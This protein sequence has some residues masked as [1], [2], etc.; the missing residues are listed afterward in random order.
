MKGHLAILIS[1]FLLVISAFSAAAIAEL[2]N[3]YSIDTDLAKQGS[4]NVKLVMTFEEPIQ[5]FNLLLP[6]KISN[7]TASSS[8]GEVTCNNQLTGVSLISCRMNLTASRKTLEIGFQSQELIKNR[9]Q[10]YVFTSDFTVKIPSKDV[11]VAIRLPEGMVLSQNVP[12]GATV[13]YTNSTSTDGRRITVIWRFQDISQKPLSF[14][15]FY[16]PVIEQIPSFGVPP[17]RVLVLLAI[18]IGGGIGLVIFRRHRETKEVVF[19]VLD[20]FEKR[21]ISAIEKE[22]GTANQKKVVVE[23]NLSKA[24]VSRVVQKLAERGLLEV[25]RRGRTNIIRF[26]KKKFGS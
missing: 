3:S 9:D 23:T 16:E 14:Q 4:A 22:G 24:K 2:L 26:V 11:F 13:P 21:V 10:G 25:E 17:L 18:I 15:V 1:S 12:G 6:F 8:S 5:S 20:D 7:F 19:S